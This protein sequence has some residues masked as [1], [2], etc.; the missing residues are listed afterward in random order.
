[1][2]EEKINYFGTSLSSA[3]HY[4]WELSAGM[5]EVNIKYGS[6]PFNVEALPY[7]EGRSHLPNGTVGYYFI[8]GFHICAIEGSCFDKRIGSRSV[9]FTRKGGMVNNELKEFI[10]SIPAAKKIIDQM[11]FEVKW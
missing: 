1:M 7:E 4:F 3:G 2:T 11:P 6:L 8:A 9:F 5:H 10:L